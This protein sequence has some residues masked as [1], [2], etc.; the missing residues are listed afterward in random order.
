MTR[1]LENTTMIQQFIKFCVVGGSGMIV[2][3]GITYLLKEL[4]HVNKYIANST[5]FICA[6]TSNY[7]LNRIWTFSSTDPHVARQ[8][9]IFIGI[10]LIGLILNNATIYLL[11]DRVRLN[12]Y[13]SKLLAI[14]V[15]TFWN[16]FM[17]Y[18]FNFSA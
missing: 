5:G 13:L 2:D 8:Y 14:G 10:S 12:F 6:A 11:N 7:I 18:F 17:N 16:F 15:V 9:L 4:L 3:F 1:L